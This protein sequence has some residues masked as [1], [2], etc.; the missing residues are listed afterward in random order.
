MR[1]GLGGPVIIVML[2][3]S[4]AGADLESALRAHERGDHHSAFWE[5]LLLAVRGDATA[6]FNVGTAYYNGRPVAADYAR[7]AEWYRRAARQGHVGAQFLL[8]LMY[9]AG[10]GVPQDGAQSAAW[11]HRAAARGH[12]PAQHNLGIMYRV[13]R[14][15]PKDLAEAA[16]WFL[17]AAEQEHVSSLVR[18]GLIYDTGE[19]R[20]PDIV[21]AY[22]WYLLAA[23]RLGRPDRGDVDIL[24][25]ALARRMSTAQLDAA[26]QLVREWR[27]R[28][29]Q[30][31]QAVVGR[32][33]VPSGPWLNHDAS[34]AG[35][36]GS[37]LDR[38]GRMQMLPAVLDRCASYGPTCRP[39][40]GSPR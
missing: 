4:T 7:A 9:D 20:S 14:G 24:L 19:G 35:G 26:R 37:V 22:K 38:A 29:E 8:G 10:R 13:G 18:A 16:Q 11:F 27:P 5:W 17:R 12:A 2:L 21:Q 3:A 23:Q 15:V 28:M 6:Q 36:A 33:R 30:I 39:A 1:R 34:S 40:G 32:P 25:G 31:D